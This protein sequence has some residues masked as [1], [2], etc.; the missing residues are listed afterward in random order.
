[1]NRALLIVACLSLWGCAVGPVNEKI[2]C[3]KTGDDLRRAGQALCSDETTVITGVSRSRG[4]ACFDLD[5]AADNYQLATAAGT[6]LEGPLDG[7]RQG[8]YLV[9]D[10]EPT[11]RGLLF[12]S[13]RDC[14]PEDGE[15]FRIIP[16][17][18]LPGTDN[19]LRGIEDSDT[20]NLKTTS[21][22]QVTA[23]PQPAGDR[24]W[25]KRAVTACFLVAT[26]TRRTSPPI[27]VE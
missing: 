26:P 27:V 6:H 11:R 23:P 4:N 13:T 16:C 21:N 24:P 5:Y 3:A 17:L 25:F 14:V 1:M 12:A 20:D 2:P 18:D 19:L 15:E 22:T 8:L 10:Q 7:E 9:L